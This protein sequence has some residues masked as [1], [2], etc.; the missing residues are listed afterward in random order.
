MTNKGF[1][2]CRKVAVV[3]H[4]RQFH[5]EVDSWN[6][7]ILSLSDNLLG[8]ASTHTSQAHART[9]LIDLEDFYILKKKKKKKKKTK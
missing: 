3:A 1:T 5:Q 6:M 8:L 9:P 2:A 7:L 4:V